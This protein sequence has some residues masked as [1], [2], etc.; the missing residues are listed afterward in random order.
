L[1]VKPAAWWL[2]K[3]EHWWRRVDVIKDDGKRLVAVTR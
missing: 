1:T 3:L 2:D